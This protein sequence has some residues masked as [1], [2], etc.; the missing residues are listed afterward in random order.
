[1]PARCVIVARKEVLDH[2]RDTGSLVSGALYA[3][4]GPAVVMLVSFSRA[5]GEDS[6]ADRLLGVMSV[7]ALVSAFTGGMNIAMDSTS[8][9]RERRSL[10]PLLLTP[11]SPRDVVV[12]KW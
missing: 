1:M 11:I 4:M 10:L 3:L 7:F 12:G 2:L 5:A 9:E 6:T 8:G